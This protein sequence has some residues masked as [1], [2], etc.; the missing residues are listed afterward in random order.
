MQNNVCSVQ[1]MEK[2]KVRQMFYNGKFG[3]HG[4]GKIMIKDKYVFIGFMWRVSEEIFLC[5][6][7]LTVMVSLSLDERQ[8]LHSIMKDLVALQMTRRQPSTTYDT[9][10]PKPVSTAGSSKRMVAHIHK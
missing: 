2:S 1:S 8:A 9:A 5:V 10:K 4:H 3:F 7:F 6:V